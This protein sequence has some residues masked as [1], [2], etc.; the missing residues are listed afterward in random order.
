MLSTPSSWGLT[1]D[2]ISFYYDLIFKE[3]VPFAL[4]H[5]WYLKGHGHHASSYSYIQKTTKL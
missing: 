3:H 4:D 2:A 5:Y 1:F